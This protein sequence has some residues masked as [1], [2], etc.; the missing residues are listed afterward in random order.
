MSLSQEPVALLDQCHGYF[1]KFTSAVDGRDFY[2]DPSRVM[3]IDEI[4]MGTRMV[5]EGNIIVI[6]K[7]PLDAVLYALTGVEP[8]GEKA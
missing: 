7:E 3:K 1:V 5:L 4:P 6:A 2:I 8:D